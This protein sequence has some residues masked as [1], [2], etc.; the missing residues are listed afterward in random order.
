MLPQLVQTDADRKPTLT[1]EMMNDLSEVG[2]E[3]D[4]AEK[5]KTV[6][7]QQWHWYPRTLLL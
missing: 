3:S 4:A 7:I 1:R 5:R 6:K 2:S